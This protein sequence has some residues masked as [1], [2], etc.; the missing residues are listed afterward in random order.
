MRIPVLFSCLTLAAMLSGCVDDIASTPPGTA[1]AAP[2]VYR[3]GPD[4][5]VRITVYGEPTLSGEYAVNTEGRISFP[6]VGMVQAGGLTLSDLTARLTTALDAT[7]YK[8]PR[9]VIDMVAYRPIYVLGEVNKAGQ[10]PFQSGMT[11]L[12]AV[13]T[14]GGFSYRANQKTVM[15]R[16]GGDAGEQ[17][18]P[19]TADLIVHPGDTV[20]IRER[21]F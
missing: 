7:Y 14:A 6:L 8:N 12:A 17:S 15:I 9:L 19:L 2:Y 11:V 5:R 20:R 1:A 18:A 4:D 10:Y 13:A 16:H 21:H 3:L